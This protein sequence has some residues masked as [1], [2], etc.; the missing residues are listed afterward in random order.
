MRINLLTLE[1][2]KQIAPSLIKLQGVVSVGVGYRYRAGVRTN[3]VCVVVGVK[4]KLSR[5]ELKQRDMTAVPETVRGIRTDVVR[6]G[7]LKALGLTGRRRPCPP[8][9][10]IGHGL[11]TAGTLGAWMKVRESLEYH[12][13]SNN[14]VMAASND[15]SLGDVIRQPGPAD[16]GVSS[17]AIARLTEY[18]RIVFGDGP[19]NG[20]K[21]DKKSSSA[22]RA[23]WWVGRSVPNAVARMFFCPYRLAVVRGGVR[24]VEQPFPNLIDAAVAKADE[25][26]VDLL[27]A[28]INKPIVGFKDLQLGERVHKVGRTT[29]HTVGTVEVVNALS[30]VNYG[31]GKGTAQ[32]EDQLII[33]GDDGTEFSAGGDSGSGILS[34]E[35]ELG[36]LLFAGGGGITVANRISNVI[37]ILGV[38]L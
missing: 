20:K 7:E 15:A 24:E 26:V 31:P 29:S 10:S 25:S 30:T 6:Y 27:I 13:L 28:I 21:D 8:G 19:S 18:A 37:A 34:M 1:A 17:D 12:I 5:A 3:E 14:H 16:G 33:K 38:R 32:F 22:V 4:D 9:Y 23:F 35:N 36:G 2:R 11:I